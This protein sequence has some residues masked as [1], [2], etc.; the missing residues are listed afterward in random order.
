MQLSL[1]GIMSIDT[2]GV[3]AV[4]R[5]FTCNC[6][7]NTRQHY[8]SHPMGRGG[9]GGADDGFGF[10]G[11]VCCNAGMLHV[12]KHHV[13]HICNPTQPQI[14]ASPSII[15]STSNVFGSSHLTLSLE[16]R[17]QWKSETSAVL[18]ADLQGTSTAN[19]LFCKPACHRLP[20]CFCL[21]CCW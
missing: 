10:G 14:P 2:T 12:S 11:G 9:W 19:F 21:C 16:A 7:N 13:L 20:F 5:Y 1:T 4:S 15:N 3:L 17:C 6:K 8:L 18:A